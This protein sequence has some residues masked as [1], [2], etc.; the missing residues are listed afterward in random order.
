MF[1]LSH[2]SM[3]MSCFEAPTRAFIDGTKI[4]SKKIINILEKKLE[5]SR[6]HIGTFCLWL[7]TNLISNVCNFIIFFFCENVHL[8]A[9]REREWIFVISSESLNMSGFSCP[10]SHIEIQR[11]GGGGKHRFFVFLVFKV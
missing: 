10:E 8:R 9:Q 7:F 4:Y 6:H 3:R 11:R 1:I 2:G 5:T